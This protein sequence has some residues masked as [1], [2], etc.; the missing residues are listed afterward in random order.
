LCFFLEELVDKQKRDKLWKIYLDKI[1]NNKD[2]LRNAEIRRIK[3]IEKQLAVINRNRM[4]MNDIVITPVVNNCIRRTSFDS[5][6]KLIPNRSS[7]E[8]LARNRRRSSLDQQIIEQWKSIVDQSKAQEQLPWPVRK[9]LI[10]RHFRRYYKKSLNEFKQIDTSITN[11]SFNHEHSESID[12][13]QSHL[14][15]THKPIDN[16]SCEIKRNTNI[17]LNPYVTYFHLP[18]NE[19]IKSNIHDLPLVTIKSDHHIIQMNDDE[20]QC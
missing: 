7:I 8:N 15:P 9:L 11:F 1:D 12:D 19:N 16:N 5:Q 6:T 18:S 13:E 2:K 3:N 10:H 14:L 17:R 20:Y 4:I